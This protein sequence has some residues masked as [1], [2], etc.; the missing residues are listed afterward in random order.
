MVDIES[1]LFSR[2][3]KSRSLPHPT[4]RNFERQIWEDTIAAIKA[5]SSRDRQLF[6]AA[7]H[8][9]VELQT[10]RGAYESL[11]FESM[12]K[13]TGILL[14]VAIANY[15]FFVLTKSAQ[16]NAR[17]QIRKKDGP[18]SIGSLANQPIPG[19]YP[20]NSSTIDS[21]IATVVDTIPHCIERALRLPAAGSERK[22]YWG[23]GLRLFSIL[24]VEHSLRDLWQSVLWDGWVLTRDKNGLRLVPADIEL[25]TFWSVW[26]W[27]QEMIAIQDSMQS[28]IEERMTGRSNEP[29]PPYQDP[30]VVGIG[31]HSKFER[32]FRFGSIS[33][34][35][36]GQVWHATENAILEGSYLAA[37][38]DAPLPCLD[39]GLSCRDLQAA[40]CVLRDCATVLASR[41]KERRLPGIASVE[42]YALQIR[43]TE[44]ERAIS[45][46]AKMS[47][48][49]ARAAVSFLVCDLSKTADLFTKGLWACPLV[50]IDS[51]ENVLITLAA[52][53]VGSAIRRIEDWLDRGGLSDRL[54]TARRGL[55][56][57]AWVREELAVRISENTLL[58]NARCSKNSVV[59]RNETQEQIDLLILLGGILIVGEVK[60]LLAPVESM[61]H[62]NYLSKL[63]DA[64]G[65]AVR[66]AAWI[67]A[68]PDAIVDHFGITS[69]DARKLRPI[70]IVVL[71]QGAGLGLLAG[72]ARVVD[73]HFLSLYLAD[74][75]YHTGAAFNFAE[76]R[77]ASRSQV[78]YENEHEAEENFETIMARPPTLNR[79]LSSAIWQT[80][81]F[82]MSNDEDL[83]IAFCN[84]DD[85]NNKDAREL[86]SSVSF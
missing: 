41:C 50:A 86:I 19:P 76:K 42:R 2:L 21:S 4:A 65:Q 60:C 51:D 27:R 45:H 61:E 71:N 46:C 28:S 80:T 36:R 17:K 52:V 82:P 10:L 81:R 53:S 78:L 39:V 3:V 43:R 56:Y 68:T 70:P 12:D 37:F 64:G 57:E 34:R 25:A 74:G 11:L 9:G 15:N 7:I 32:R 23:P 14:S 6:D 29:I 66:K 24:S 72:G 5:P 69:A 73:F 83:E 22:D 85:R 79:F 77:G 75:E 49:K 13:R 8:F 20:G 84:F 40:W 55:R 16:D 26:N 54:A 31:G 38:I 18:L 1:E 48:E 44:I 59:R 47:R 35:E 62:F 63:N 58:P 30:T 67:A 33:G